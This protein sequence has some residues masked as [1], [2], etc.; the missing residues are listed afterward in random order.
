M[1]RAA[2]FDDAMLYPLRARGV[3]RKGRSFRDLLS[4]HINVMRRVDLESTVVEPEIHGDADAG[5]AA[6]VDLPSVSVTLIPFSFPRVR[7]TIS[8]ASVPATTN[9]RSA[10]FFQYPKNSGNR[11][12]RRS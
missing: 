11:A 3:E 2:G 1:I 5:N 8:A 12:N 7:L 10:Y 6:L 4:Y 9:S